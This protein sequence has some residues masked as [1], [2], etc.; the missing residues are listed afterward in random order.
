MHGSMDVAS[1]SMLAAN[2]AVLLRRAPRLAAEIAAAP[3]PTTHVLSQAPDGEPLLAVAGIA[4]QHPRDP[5]GDG[6]RWA[7]AAVEKIE[8]SGAARAIVVGLGLGYHVDALAERFAGE[9]VVVEPDLAVWRCALTARDLRGMLERVTAWSGDESD[10]NGGAGKTRVLQ[11]APSALRADGLHRELFERLVGRSGA[12]GLRLRVL[13]VSPIAGGSLPIARYATRA[14]TA[15]GHEVR[16]L[17][18]SRFHDGLT[19]LATFGA[20]RRR[21]AELESGLCSVLGMGVAAATESFAPDVVLALAQAPLDVRALAAIGRTGA[22][23]ALWFIEDFRRFTYWQDV[24]SQYDHVF[25]IQT[26]ECFAALRGATDARLTYLPCAFDPDEH[27]P[28]DLSE[29]ERDT[30]GSDVSFVGAGYRN[31]RVTFRRFLDLDFRIWGSEWNGAPE[32]ERVV[33][34]D[35]A[36][37]STEESV[38]I[39]NAT[40]VNLNLHSST[41]HDGV[42]PLGDFVN[43]R[44]FELAG[45]GAF[46]IVDRRQLLPEAFVPGSEIAVAESVAEMRDLTRHFLAHPDERLAMAQRAHARALA[47]HTY[48]H[49]MQDLI[50]AVVA[51][52]QDRLLARSR[53]PTFGEAAARESG[54]LRALLERHPA[55]APFSLDAIVRGIGEG[56]GAVSEEEAIFLFLHQFQELYLTEARA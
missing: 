24:A 55:S 53:P 40:R 35:S 46:Q 50:A 20:R 7:R 43:P 47:Q 22:I 14:L 17:D 48:Q 1:E 3:T 45:C 33:Q 44:T 41:Y 15:L 9:I 27:R 52:D 6:V 36:R 4:L 37:I 25:T 23:R 56:Q 16:L 54:D 42:D 18:L 38:R 34:R 32:L 21:Q 2:L 19:G 8:A 31:R 26:D 28:L 30:L 11:H 29:D 5:R 10:A 13:V 39:F 49:R 51:Q 12:T